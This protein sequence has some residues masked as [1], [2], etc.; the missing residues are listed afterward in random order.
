MN[1]SRLYGLLAALL[2]LL[3]VSVFFIVR[4][5]KLSGEN[6]GMTVELDSLNSVKFD[7]L[8][9]IDSL[10]TEYAVT[11]AKSDSLAGSLSSAES[12][13]AQQSEEL[14]RIK[15]QSAANSDQLKKEIVQLRNLKA[16]MEG[17]IDDLRAQ[18]EKLKEENTFLSGELDKAQVVNQDLSNRAGQL[19]EANKSLQ[20]EMNKLRAKSVKAT[21]FRVDVGKRNDKP[22]TSSKR[23][24]NVG[25]SF[26][27]LDVPQEYQGVHTLY[28]VITDQQ[29][30][31]V[32]AANPIR[33]TIRVGEET[34]EIE[35]QQAKEVN[36]GPT[37]RLVFNYSPPDRLKGGTY[38]AAI[39]T[40][41]GL[42]GTVSFRLT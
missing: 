1:K 10:R 13:M 24:R 42:L 16:Q 23:V 8:D 19:E 37:Q 20:E 18:N 7:L 34:A 9:E 22:T 26:D 28:L 2:L 31:P 38:Q 21:G 11:V 29:G 41:F 35:A 27:L 14:R 33:T 32:K 30:I 40:D 5:S 3:L 15:R 6:K 39:Y 36:I 4:S 12:T 17:V 25:I